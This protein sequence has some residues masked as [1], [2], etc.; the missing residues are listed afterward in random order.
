MA[1]LK[2]DVNDP[3]YNESITLKLDALN[4]QWRVSCALSRIWEHWTAGSL[5]PRCSHYEQK[6]PPP[7]DQLTPKSLYLRNFYRNYGMGADT[8]W[9]ET[10]TPPEEAQAS[11]EAGRALLAKIAHL[12]PKPR[13]IIIKQGVQHAINEPKR[14]YGITKSRKPA[15]KHTPHSMVTRT[16]SLSTRGHRLFDLEHPPPKEETCQE[17]IGI[18]QSIP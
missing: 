12:M 15:R 1:T 16:R 8:P 6:T 10:P 11:L 5:S 4:S 7:D 2:P 14:Q 18:M 13:R 9:I 3:D 17:G